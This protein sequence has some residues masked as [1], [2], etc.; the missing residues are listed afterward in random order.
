MLVHPLILQPIFRPKVWGGRHLA[1]LLGKALPPV[2][3]I[4]ESWECADLDASQSVVA[5]GPAK[6]KTLHELIQTWGPALTGHVKLIDGR[7]PLLLKFL[8]AAQALSIQ[9]HPYAEPGNSPDRQAKPKHEAW[10]VL[11]ADPGACIYRGLAPGATIE[12][13]RSTLTTAPG[14]VVEQL[15]RIPVKAGEAYYVPGGVAHA[16]G[17]GVV[18][19]EVQTPSDVTYRLYDFGRSRPATDAGLHIDEALACIR[20]GI[21]FR[22][23]EKRSHASSVFT[24]VTRL[25]TCPNFIVEKV[26]LM[27]GCEIEI[28]YAEPVCWMVLAGRG[29]VVYGRADRQ[30]FKV[31]DVVLLPATLKKPRVKAIEDCHWL[32]VTIP[33]PSDLAD[34]PRPDASSL[35]G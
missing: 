10:Y 35:R 15:R 24:T 31:G 21:D 1:E 27:E 32:E 29:E 30:P 18:V 20:E 12:T 6:D 16:L 34:F 33:V 9:V 23:F 19:A 17:A 7:F 22:P 5:A 14:L 13:L 26:R 25:I 11:K 8:D 2:E 4:G 3:L 28:P